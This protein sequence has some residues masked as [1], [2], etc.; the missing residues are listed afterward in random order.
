[1]P[2][3]VYEQIRSYLAALDKRNEWQ[4]SVSAYYVR[5]RN[6]NN[7]SSSN[8]ISLPSISLGVIK[9][10]TAAWKKS[11][12]SLPQKAQGVVSNIDVARHINL[13]G[14]HYVLIENS[15]QGKLYW[16]NRQFDD[17][18]NRTSVGYAYKSAK[19][20][21]RMLPFYE[22]RWSGK[23]RYSKGFGVRLAQDY[24]FTD[25]LQ[26]SNA[27]EWKKT[28]YHQNA[29]LNGT[30]WLVSSTLFAQLSPVKYVYAGVDWS[31]ERA[32]VARYS[33]KRLSVRAGWGKAWA[34]GV[35]SRLNLSW[36]NR[37]YDAQTLFQGGIPLG[38]RRDNTYS[39]TLTLWKKDWH[40]WH[41]T[42][43]RQL[44]WT[45]QVSSIPDL[46]SYQDRGANIIFEKTF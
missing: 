6:V 34:K 19:Q 46:Y 7:A 39:A 13:T 8:T 32:A 30:N 25:N 23:H 18:Y 22:R 45:K 17:Y 31:R 4:V 1:M 35:T 21:W 14:K 24:W 10:P 41:I 44:N 28:R 9:I 15:F 42:P 36:A 20:S 43:K 12:Q 37:R 5:E 33:Y 27:V 40:L 26:L 3:I 16:D 2:A 11:A 38:M 29:E